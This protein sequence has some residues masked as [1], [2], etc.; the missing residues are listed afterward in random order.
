MSQPQSAD[1]LIY[2][3]GGEQ[4]V[5]MLH[6]LGANALELQRI[7]KELHAQGFTVVAPRIKGYTFESDLQPW[8]SW[9]EQAQSKIWDLQARYS[10]VSLVGISMGAVLALVLAQKQEN[11]LA[12]LVILS[13]AL[14]FDGWNM[15]W[16]R[17]FLFVPSW[18]PFVSRYELKESDPFGIKNQE[19]RS[20]VRALMRSQN[21]S[22]SGADKL[23]YGQIKQGE[24]LAKEAR[25]NIQ[26]IDCPC[27]IMHAVDDEVVHV[28]HAE[29]VY[30]HIKSEE[31]EIIYLGD[32]YHMITVD[33]ERDTVYEETA[34]FLKKSVNKYV[35][36]DFFDVP[37]IKSPQIRRMLQKIQSSLF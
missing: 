19:M 15:P 30:R 34:R 35:G 33:N 23:T 27:L 21:I 14:E 20:A 36:E 18:V 10:S 16:Y 28:R 25:N 17:V 37:F 2:H 24:A 31:K 11:A 3:E 7:A 22:E 29:W 12:G 4:C 13:A 6:G 9:V 26:K 32:S 1:Y 8:T 5:M